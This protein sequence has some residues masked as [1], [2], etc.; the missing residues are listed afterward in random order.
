M[1][2]DQPRPG[3]I[4]LTSIEGPVGWGI[5]LGQLLNGNG[6]SAYEHA[7]VVL[8]GGRLIEAQPGGARIAPLSM[9]H[10][11]APLGLTV[12]P[13]PGE[14]KTVYVAPPG[15]TDG[16]RVL[17]CAAAE[18]YLGVGYSAAEYL[19]LAAH[20]FH[21]PVPGLRRY[22]AS[23]HRMICSQLVDQ[24]YQDAGVRLFND[25]RWPGWVTPGSLCDLLGREEVRR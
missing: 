25:G 5:R 16:Q 4:G 3:S 1:I 19:A 18:R 12:P 15:L 6:F 2:E 7:F 22:I 8:D 13:G 9:Y 20:R 11:R 21:V 17:I 14:R 10:P 23:S 24:A